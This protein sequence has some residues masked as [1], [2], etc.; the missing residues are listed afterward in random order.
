MEGFPSFAERV[1]MV[2][3][4][5]AAAVIGIMAPGF[6]MDSVRAAANGAEIFDPNVAPLYGA[7]SWEG[8]ATLAHAGGRD[9]ASLL[10]EQPGSSFRPVPLSLRAQFAADTP[11]RRFASSNVIGR[12]AGSGDH[13][14]AVL[15][16][17]HWD[18]LGLCRPAGQPDRICNG[19]VD[20]AS[21]VASLIEMAD[22]LAR[23]PRSARDVL[24]LAT[25]SEESGLL[26]AEYFGRNPPIPAANVVAALNIDSPAIAP[27]GTPVAVVGGH[28]RDGAGRSVGSRSAQAAASTST[29]RRTGW[30]IDRM[31]SR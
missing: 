6:P 16:L 21:G 29:G 30:R 26:G 24:F 1:R 15:L 7:M 11:Q 27:A 20:N 17:A 14:E 22:R 13:R 5:G 4:A 28:A 23:G 8:A 3:R 19:A 31:G 9:M 25:T 2:S 18:G 12:V 10:N